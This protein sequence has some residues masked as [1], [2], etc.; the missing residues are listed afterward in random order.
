MLNLAE[1]KFLNTANFN[2]VSQ[3]LQR[4]LVVRRPTFTLKNRSFASWVRTTDKGK[5]FEE[6][7]RVAEREG[8]WRLLRYPL[9]IAVIGSVSL[10]SYLT[11]ENFEMMVALL[12]AL[13]SGL[14]VLIATFLG[15]RPE[16]PR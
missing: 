2:V 14:P 8:A 13:L 10:L 15:G 12:P 9:L 7:R 6:F 1:G 4:G 5:N 3:L 11:Q 16:V